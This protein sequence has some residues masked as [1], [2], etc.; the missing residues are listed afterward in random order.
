M[1]PSLILLTRH[2]TFIFLEQKKIAQ[3]V[4][5]NILQYKQKREQL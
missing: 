4:D 5:K 3:S 2:P 1:S